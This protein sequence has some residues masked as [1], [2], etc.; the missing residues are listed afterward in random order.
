MSFAA[1]VY[2]I[3]AAG[4]FAFMITRPPVDIPA[5]QPQA[6]PAA[7]STAPASST[8]TTILP[9][10]PPKATDP[11]TNTTQPATSAQ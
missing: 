7:E 2:T 1:T 5:S 8:S 6:T 4:A 3:A 11:A 9:G 10:S